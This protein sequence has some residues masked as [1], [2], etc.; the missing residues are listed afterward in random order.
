MNLKTLL[1]AGVLALAGPALGH[2]AKGPNGGRVTDAGT[3]HV[4]LV[5]KQNTLELFVSD[6]GEKPVPPTGFKA[7]AIL[8]VDGKPLRITLEPSDKGRLTGKASV[9]LPTLPK[10]VVQLTSPDGKTAQAKFN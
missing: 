10:G 7:L 1:L 5:A 3:Y 4:E 9:T 6:A 2:D 8:V